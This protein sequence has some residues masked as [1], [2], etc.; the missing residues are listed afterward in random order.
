M[1]IR[2][3]SKKD[4]CGISL[5]DTLSRF[6]SKPITRAQNILANAKQN[7]QKSKN[8]K[9]NIVIIAEGLGIT[10][11]QMEEMHRLLEKCSKVE[12]NNKMKEKEQRGKSD[13]T[14]KPATARKL[15]APFVKVEDQSR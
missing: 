12:L 10:V 8:G 15:R 5:L 11:L 2:K 14:E 9:R 13:W 4:R 7:Q 6:S 3:E 1:L